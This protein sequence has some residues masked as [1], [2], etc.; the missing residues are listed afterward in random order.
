VVS[1]GRI[2]RW[3][4]LAAAIGMLSCTGA[5][6]PVD[7]Q[8]S[9]LYPNFMTLER[10]GNLDVTLFGGGFGSD[11]YGVIQEGLQVE[12]SVTP[13]VGVFGRATG[14]QLFVGDDSS[15]PFKPTAAHSPRLNFGSLQGGI[16]L[17]LYPG[18]S[19]FLSGG[20]GVADSDGSIIEGDFSTWLLPHSL[21]PVNFSFSSMHDFQ[22]QV[23]STEID[24]QVV[25]LS[26]EQWL[27]MVG[28]GGAFYAGGF[29][30]GMQGQGGPDL[31][32]FY[33]QWQVGVSVQAGDGS[34]HGYGQLSIYKLLS[35]SG[36]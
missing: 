11:T 16:D 25:V 29:L 24:V 34:S 30:S 19:L 15:S 35:Y 21:H 28:G 33:R 14:Y 2:R 7:A 20:H 36:L 18:T 32:L 22:N 13:Y 5:V 12:Q 26:T 3:I 31:S 6:S 9:D 27:A 17:K 1:P 4:C 23:T 8:L 10:P